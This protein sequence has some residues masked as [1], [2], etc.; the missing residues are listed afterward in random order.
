MQPD[1]M[2]IKHSQYLCM[3]VCNDDGQKR[4]ASFVD[5]QPQAMIVRNLGSLHMSAAK[6]LAAA[7][8]ELFKSANI[9]DIIN[10]LYKM[11]E[12]SMPDNSLAFYQKI[13]TPKWACQAPKPL[14]KG[15]AGAVAPLGTWEEP[16]NLSKGSVVVR[17]VVI[18]GDKMIRGVRGAAPVPAPA[19]ANQAAGRR[20]R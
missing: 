6:E 7:N 14:L 13:G 12:Q 17:G 1:S 10:N 18:G 5:G 20:M 3:G 19:K 11:A 9:T 2:G 16:D 4:D 8:Q 15:G